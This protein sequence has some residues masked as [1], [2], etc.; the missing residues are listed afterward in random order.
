MAKLMFCR[1][2]KKKLKKQFYEIYT[3][4]SFNNHVRAQQMNSHPSWTVTEP[5]YYRYQLEVGG[6]VS[7]FPQGAIKL[8][9]SHVTTW[10][11]PYTFLQ[12]K[13]WTLKNLLKCVVLYLI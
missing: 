4:I 6:A 9:R 3:F 11:L 13:L 2:Y 12:I 8:K 5:G 7:Y 10:K 1:L